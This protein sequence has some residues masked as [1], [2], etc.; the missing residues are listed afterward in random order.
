MTAEELLGEIARRALL[1]A[2]GYGFPVEFTVEKGYVQLTYRGR[3]TRYKVLELYDPS[4][5]VSGVGFAVPGLEA[6]SV[7]VAEAAGDDSRIFSLVLE[8]IPAA[9]GLDAYFIPPAETDIWVRRFELAGRLKRVEAP[10]EPLS[11]LPSLGFEVWAT[12]D[13][14]EYAVSLEGVVGLWYV[15]LFRRVDFAMEIQEKLGVRQWG[16]A[17]VEV[18]KLLGL[19]P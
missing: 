15:P 10:P 3:R 9:I 7:R 2:V 11:R 6:H 4:G 5:R 8:N 19:A 1:A 13:E 16:A 18:K 14:L 17:A 12:P